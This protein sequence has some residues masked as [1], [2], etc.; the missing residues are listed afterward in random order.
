MVNDDKVRDMIL[1]WIVED[2][3]R[4]NKLPGNEDRLPETREGVLSEQF[5]IIHVDEVDFQ[6]YDIFIAYTDV[7]DGGE[8]GGTELMFFIDTNRHYDAKDEDYRIVHVIQGFDTS[9][10]QLFGKRY[11]DNNPPR[12]VEKV[13]YEQQF[14]VDCNGSGKKYIAGMN[15]GELVKCLNCDGEGLVR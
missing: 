3:S 6:A 12:W 2:I 14:C 7:F 9:V 1:D 13:V 5:A 10:E 11:V 8:G 4:L 15:E